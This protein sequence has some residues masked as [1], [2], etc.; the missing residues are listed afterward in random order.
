MGNRDVAKD[1]MVEARDEVE[2]LCSIFKGN[3]LPFFIPESTFID[4]YFTIILLDLFRMQTKYFC[5][6]LRLR[7]PAGR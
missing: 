1:E 2:I 3:M 4:C 5:V 7:M 6:G